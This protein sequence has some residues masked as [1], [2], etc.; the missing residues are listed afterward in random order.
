MVLKI[1]PPIWF[2]TFLAL[3]LLAHFFVPATHIFRVS[4]PYVSIALGAAV[5]CVGFFL[6][7]W[8]SKIF[9]EEKTEILPTSPAN[10]AFVTRGPFRFSRNPMYLGITLMLVG[11]AIMLG[12]APMFVSAALFFAVMNFTFIPF[13]EEK[14]GRQFGD[15]FTGYTQRVRRWL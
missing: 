10:R 14:M 11:I 9:A 13:E 4:F 3:G 8:A 15:A 12:T 2:A 7:Q 1:L 5:F 6:S